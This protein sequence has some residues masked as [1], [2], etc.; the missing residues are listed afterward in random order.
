[1]IRNSAQK[2]LTSPLP[3]RF[4]TDPEAYRHLRDAV[5]P[6][7]WQWAFGPESHLPGGY[8]LP[9]TLL[10]GFL[11]E[12]LAALADAEGNMRIVA[13]VC[14]HRGHPLV[15]STGP[16][17]RL[18]CPYHARSFDLNGHC[19][20]QPGLGDVDGFPGP[21]D[22]LHRPDH[23]QW[24]PFH[25]VRL[26]GTGPDLKDV[27]AP[28]VHRL[29]FL[30]LDT[31]KHD[32]ETSRDYL[33]DANWA[34]YVENFLEGLHIPFVHPAL[35]RALDPLDYPVHCDGETVLQVGLAKEGEHDFTLPEG[36]PDA[37]LSVYAWYFWV[38]PNL[39]VNAYPWGLSLNVVEPT[40]QD[41]T[42]VR[43]ITYRFPNTEGSPAAYALDATELED[44]SVVEAVRSGV[45][46][47]YYRP[48][49]L[50][51]GWED[52]VVHFHQRLMNSLSD[53]LA[54]KDQV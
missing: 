42:R 15:R 18:V 9:F 10:P 34:L 22:H 7:S 37:G 53:P 12:P 38:F 19:L 48:G 44:E 25:F 3:G 40:G 4:Y 29:G 51:P 21:E 31:L 5:F 14:T 26:A 41:S 8:A 52:G 20:G 39:M 54:P 32:P 17:N 24:G 27:L 45:R 6:A 1:M 47:R 30:P 49:R 35:S 23:D 2:A 13:N 16:V 50:V 43:F 11:D 28:L 36:H 33:I 46:S